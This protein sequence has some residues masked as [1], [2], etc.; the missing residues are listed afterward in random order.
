MRTALLL[1][2]ALVCVSAGLSA[3]R[4]PEITSYDECV[5]AGHPQLKTYPGQCVL[6]DGTRFVQTLPEPP[7]IC[8]DQCGD[9]QC[10][11]VVCLGSGCPCAETVQ[12]CPQDCRPS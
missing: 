5:A 6:P 12:S 7:S 1:S 2:L 9:G 11:E 8:Q 4:K 10:Q 3:C